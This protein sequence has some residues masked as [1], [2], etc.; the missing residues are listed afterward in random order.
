M[1][2]VHHGGYTNE[3]WNIPSVAELTESQEMA[4][5]SLST[6]MSTE[7]DSHKCFYMTHSYTTLYNSDRCLPAGS[8]RESNDGRKTTSEGRGNF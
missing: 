8:H 6:A 5:V 3:L 2:N 1:P 4:W 7:G